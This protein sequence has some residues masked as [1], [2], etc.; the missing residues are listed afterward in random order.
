MTDDKNKDLAPEVDEMDDDWDLDE[1]DRIVL[2]L[3]DDTE[4]ECVILDIFPFQD[5]EYIALFPVTEE[6]DADE[7]DEGI[8]LY[9]YAESEDGEEIELSQIESEEEYNAVADEFDRLL[10]EDEEEGECECG[11]DHD[12]SQEED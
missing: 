8:L 12:H 6:E 3:D 4:L 2:T 11:C 1:E 5:K 9:A 10:A 7:E